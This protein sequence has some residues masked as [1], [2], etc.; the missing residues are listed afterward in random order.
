MKTV[1]VS[2]ARPNFMKIAPVVRAFRERDYR[3]FVIVHT[4]QHYDYA[5]SQVFFEELGLPEPDHCLNAGSGSHAEQTGKIMVEFEKVCREIQPDVIVVVGDVNSTLACSIV[6]KK[7]C[8]RV[9][10]VEAGL[11]SRDLSMPEEINR[12]VTDAIADIC[13]ASEK[14]GVA[15][16]R[17]EGKSDG[18]VH[19]VGN[20]MIDTLH[21]QLAALQQRA[22]LTGKRSNGNYA[23]VTLHRPSNVDD[24]VVLGGIL[25]ALA[26]I[27]SVLPV[28]FPVHPRTSRRLEECRMLERI[29]GS[30]IELMPP[31]SYKDFLALWKDA[32]V[33]L[34][35]SGGL[36]EETTALGIPCLTLRT[37][38]ERPVTVTEGTNVL[39]GNRRDDILRAFAA[40]G[41]ERRGSPRIPEMW[42]GQAAGRIA[43]IL[44]KDA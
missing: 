43:D 37:S 12:I 38:T 34:T 3:D 29:E 8:C 2:G 36:Q 24:A 30:G 4:G 23:V 14:S 13:F 10:H 6:G 39:V 1:L 41:D 11:R 17:A 27:A 32:S 25:D 20:V 40:C 22:P 35:D 33:V 21:Y 26:E 42:D 7:L 19:F 16:L 31:L 9:A 18:Q 28:K 15:N 5:M 44:L